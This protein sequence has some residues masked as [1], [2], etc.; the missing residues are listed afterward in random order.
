MPIIARMA[1]PQH[2]EMDVASHTQM[3]EAKANGWVVKGES[4]PPPPFTSAVLPENHYT[5]EFVDELTARAEKAEAEVK[6]LKVD[7]K[8]LKA[9]IK[10]LKVPPLPSAPPLF[11]PGT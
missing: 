1:H 8:A 7:I 4:S 11:N 2:G 6:E 9:E 10:A 5:Q 3:E